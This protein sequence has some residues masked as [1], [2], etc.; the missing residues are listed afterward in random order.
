MSEID[1]R[2]TEGSEHDP[3]AHD[4]AAHELSKDGIGATMRDEPNTF[5]PEEGLPDTD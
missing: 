1:D 5:E 3:T 4:T 2:P